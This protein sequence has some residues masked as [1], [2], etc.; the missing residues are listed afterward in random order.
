MFKKL[1]KKIIAHKIISFLVIVVLIGAGYFGYKALNK[2]DNAVKYAFAAVERGTL[3]VSISGSGQ[4]V[5][6]SQVEIKPKVS[7]ELVYLNAEA[8]KEVKKGTLLAQ[9][10]ASEAQ[11]T[12]RNAELALEQAKLSLAKMEGMVTPEGTIRGVK[13][14]AEGDL[15][16]AYEDGF[17]TVANI[18]LELPT[19]MSGINGILFSYD[20]ELN[21][22][23]ISYYADS[24]R[25]YNEDKVN[26]YEKDAYQKYVLARDAYD[27]NLQDYKMASRFLS[28]QEIKDLI[29]ETY[30]TVKK[31][32]ESIKSANNLIQFYRD[33]LSRRGIR[34][35][36]LCE[37]H[38]S[39]LS[40]YTGKTNNYLLNLLSIKNTILSSE[41]KLIEANFDINDQKI[42]V[43]DAE[44]KL[45]EA[46]EKVADYY[47]RAPFD[48]VIAKVG[49]ERGDTVG[50]ST[51]ICTLITKKQIAEIS[52][53]E[54]DAAKVKVGQK[55]TLTFDAVEGLTITG[56]V[57][58]V[59]SV[60][61]VSQGVVSYGVKIGLDTLDER[62]KPGMTVSAAIIVEA[63]QNVLLVPAS[64]I[65]TDRGVSYVEVVKGMGDFSNTA[66]ISG[67]SDSQSLDRREVEPGT[68]NDTMVEIL[69]G[70][71]EGEI[72]IAQ[73]INVNNSSTQS[74]R[75]SQFRMPMMQG[76]FSR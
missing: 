29:E 23:N 49:A 39:N 75:Q 17:N 44:D 15:N 74:S 9:I 72:V 58:G 65:K 47:L 2:K 8:G 7:G 56:E 28:Q 13:E 69:S 18:F 70:L 12:V 57:L 38:L 31:I 30:D 41:E 43:K 62:I 53:N 40:S 68:S 6:L 42:K 27:K 51:S 60:G 21:Q 54:V 20:F 25:I 10:D 48:G 36:S 19:V 11:K 59:D 26:M 50:A 24:V 3:I 1:V 66:N 46:K 45:G 5:A 61:T 33:E 37:T 16:K 63:K 55:A 32:A 34:I 76:G 35:Q 71:A 52:L 64:A 22:Q 4:V 67:I 73:T 14:K